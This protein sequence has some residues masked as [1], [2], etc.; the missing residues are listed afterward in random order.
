M[1]KD[2]R[3]CTKC[4]LDTSDSDITF[5]NEGVCNYC[6]NFAALMSNSLSGQEANEYLIET[7]KK[8]KASRKGE[9]DCIVG[10][11]GGVDSTYVAYL[12]KQHGL[13]PLAVHIDAGWNSEIA[14]KN[15]ES[16]TNRLGIDLETIV[17][18][19]KE[20]RDLQ[21]A[22][23]KASVP[24]CDVPQDH[25]F[26]AG[27]YNLAAK[28]GIQYII[29]GHNNVTEFIL[30]PSWGYDSGDLNNLIDIHSK[31]GEVKLKTYPRLSLFKKIIYYRYFKNL[32]S[33][34]ILNYVSYDKENVKK[35]IA[36]NLGWKDYGGKHF[37]SR[38]TKF[39]QSYY[40][41]IKFGF[42]KRR[43]HLSNLIASGQISREDAL[44]ELE[45]LPYNQTEIMEDTEYFIK[46]LGFSEDEW[47]EIMES[48]P[49]RHTDFKSDYNQWW[50]R[51]LKAIKRK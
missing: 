1:K 2:Y 6:N 23:F 48:R 34:R 32:K 36:D 16:A 20:V 51:L 8:I 12:A 25:A 50:F 42:D 24:N 44:R 15:I 31:Y 11:S 38:F 43:A 19:W 3:I 5:D 40:L 14:V 22:Y 17:V 49:R 28:Y 47:Q 29:S 37:E 13:N 7:V 27:I 33:L 18:N 4:V 46:K 10:M 30:P 9:Y 21:R 26:M 45:N 39:F 35:F 41:P